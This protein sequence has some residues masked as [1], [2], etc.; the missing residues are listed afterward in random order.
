MARRFGQLYTAPPHT[1]VDDEAV[2]KREALTGLFGLVPHCS[3]DTKI[4]RHTYSDRRSRHP[5]ASN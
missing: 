2:P 4:T 3:Q 5:P 1:G